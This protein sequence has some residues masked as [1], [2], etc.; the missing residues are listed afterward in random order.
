MGTGFRS[1]EK[2]FPRSLCSCFTLPLGG[3]NKDDLARWSFRSSSDTSFQNSAR[4]SHTE[5]TTVS[6]Q[7][8]F[9]CFPSGDLS[10]EILR[11]SALTVAAV[12]MSGKLLFSFAAVQSIREESE[13][14][15]RTHRGRGGMGRFTPQALMKQILVGGICWS[16]KAR[17]S[18]SVLYKRF[19]EVKL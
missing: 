16:R 12:C 6:A 18:V 10:G 15:M 1:D 2:A 11:T 17:I 5:L 8:C 19:K 4:V 3:A 14:T 7:W 9:V 13:K